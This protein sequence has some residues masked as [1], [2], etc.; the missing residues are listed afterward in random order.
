MKMMKLALLGG[1]ALAVTAAGARADDLGALKAEIEALNARVAQLETAPAVPAGYQL[2]TL[3]SGAETVVPG[4]PDNAKFG[5]QVAS[6]TKVSVMP[7]ADAP[8]AA[9]IEWSG[10]VRAAIA[11]YEY[12]DTSVG[13]YNEVGLAVRLTTRRR[14]VAGWSADVWVLQEVITPAAG[15][16]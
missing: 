10:Y 4:N 11:C 8:A 6:V 3:S 5:S 14:M 1:A 2:M 13:V 9:S 12:R 15:A 16:S 7:T